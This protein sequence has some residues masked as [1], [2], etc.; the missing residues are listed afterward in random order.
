V[1]VDHLDRPVMMTDHSGAIVWRADYLPFGEV[2]TGSG[3][4]SLDYRFPG[5]W[6]M[7]ETG[8][9]YNWHRWYDSSTGRYTQP[10]PIGMPDGPSRYAYALNSPL[11]NVD[12]GGQFVPSYSLWRRL[13]S[14]PPREGGGF[15]PAPD[16]DGRHNHCNRLYMLCDA[17]KWGGMWYCD[18][19]FGYCL[20]EGVWPFEYC[21]LDLP[22][23][24]PDR[25]FPPK[26]RRGR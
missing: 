2:R 21:S 20:R 26:R 23:S 5:Q 14:D 24:R 18:E 12:R 17:Q 8:L 13:F 6:F 22:R 19:C 7:L 10:D 11:M 3:P 25:R 15:C 9:H 4:A 16:D 1:H